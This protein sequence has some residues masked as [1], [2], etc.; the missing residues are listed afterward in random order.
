[1]PFTSTKD[2]QFGDCYFDISQTEKRLV[3]ATLKTYERTGTYVFLKLFKKAA[4]DYEFEQRISLTLEEFGNLVKKKNKYAN[5]QRKIPHQN[6]PQQRSRNLISVAM[7]KQCLS[8]PQ[9]FQTISKAVQ[10]FDWCRKVK[11]NS[12]E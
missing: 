2:T 5:L 10:V 6:H 4:E 12:F 11:L 1:M 3:R 8:D 7:W 9:L